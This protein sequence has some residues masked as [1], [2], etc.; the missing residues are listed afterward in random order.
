M[1]DLNTPEMR[2]QQP[3]PTKSAKEISKWSMVVAA[4]WIGILSI[5]KAL[6]FIFARGIL[7]ADGT[8][9]AAPGFGL[10]MSEI[11][12]SGLAL[13]A[14]FTPVYFSIFLEK[15]KDIKTGGSE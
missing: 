8:V 7:L 6:W 9:Q 3:K 4:L 1:S 13:A 15:I 12:Y 2:A 14:V 10:S 5:V 11:I